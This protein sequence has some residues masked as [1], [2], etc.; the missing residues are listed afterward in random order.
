MDRARSSAAPRC[1]TIEEQGALRSA[2]FRRP[3]G[4]P[5]AAPPLHLDELLICYS[6]P[7]D[8][9]ESRP[10]AAR[11]AFTQLTCNRQTILPLA[12]FYP[13]FIR[14]DTAHKQHASI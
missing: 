9:Q 14:R 8:Q 7:P 12:T 2:A 6:T 10:P 4:F 3:A 1:A 5:R 13:A 11:Y